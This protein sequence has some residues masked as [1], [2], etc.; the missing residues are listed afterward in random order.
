M[1]ITIYTLCYNEEK[2]LP[3]VLDHYKKYLPNAEII[4]YDNYSTDNSQ[5]IVL[6]AG[7]TVRKFDTKNTFNDITHMN[8]K[9]S[10]WKE[11]SKN[12][13]VLV[14]DLDE[15]PCVTEDDLIN[16]SNN[17]TTV[18]SFEGYTLIGGMT[19]CDLPSLSKGIRDGG[20]DKKHIFNR[21][22]IK[23]INYA[24]GAHTAN[25]VGNVKYS[26]KNYRT[27]HYK[28]I[29]YEYVRDR[30]NMYAARMSDVNK[31]MGL[32]IQYY[33]WTNE[34][35]LEVYNSLTPHLIDVV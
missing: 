19:G 28:W 32:A 22:Q 21:K 35:L 4:V 27:L 1:S 20:H 11:E 30:H 8:L 26:D 12:D 17:G 29:S 7:H 2:I 24:P 31:K 5:K 23:E 15:L 13:W 9:N 16:E 33:Q 10:V 34:K 6:D 18:L 14:S 25:P 3:F